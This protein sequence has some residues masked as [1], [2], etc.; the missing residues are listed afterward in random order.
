M[1]K[2][3]GIRENIDSIA[4]A[5]KPGSF[6]E[7]SKEEQD[8]LLR[9]NFKKDIIKEQSIEKTDEQLMGEFS[10]MLMTRKAN[11]NPLDC[12]RE[13]YRHLLNGNT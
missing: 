6:F 12:V 2:L 4:D 7:L 11:M 8:Y 5:A 1:K 13:S 3:T 10:A 9:R